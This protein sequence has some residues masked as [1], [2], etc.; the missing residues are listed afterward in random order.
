MPDLTDPTYR[1]LHGGAEAHM[2]AREIADAG[3]GVI[4]TPP[5][6]FPYSWEKRRMFVSSTLWIS[7]R[8]LTLVSGFEDSLDRL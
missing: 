7:Y 6:Q 8:H 1:T 5:R 3:V 2:L 4:V